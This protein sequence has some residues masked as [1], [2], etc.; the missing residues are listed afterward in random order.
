M[1]I[2]HRQQLL[3]GVVVALPGQEEA[4]V[5][6]LDRAKGHGELSLDKNYTNRWAVI[7]NRIRCF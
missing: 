1:R 5:H 7:S 2:A 6:H 4:E 3:D